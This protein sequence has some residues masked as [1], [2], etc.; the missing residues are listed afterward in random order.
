MKTIQEVKEELGV[1]EQ[2]VYKWIREKKLKTTRFGGGARPRIRI[3]QEQLDDF[4][5]S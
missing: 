5:S 3:T 2:T 1:H 4:L